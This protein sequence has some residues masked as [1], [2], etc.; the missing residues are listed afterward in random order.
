MV[1]ERGFDAGLSM[2]IMLIWLVSMI[3]GNLVGGMLGDVL[4]KRDIRG[5][6][7]LGVVVV[8]LSLQR[9]ILLLCGLR[10]MFSDSQ[11]QVP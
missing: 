5:R 10:G 1:E 2:Y 3:I 7:I 9:C 6:V 4:F 8:F 11:S